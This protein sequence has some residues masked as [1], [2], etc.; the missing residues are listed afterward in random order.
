MTPSLALMTA[1]LLGGTAHATPPPEPRPPVSDETLRDG[2]ETGDEIEARVDGDLNGDGDPDTAYVV[3]S[4]DARTLYVVLSYRTE[5]DFGH[6]PAGSAK[7]AADRLGEHSLKPV[8][9][10][11]AAV[12]VSIV[13]VLLLRYVLDRRPI[14]T[15]KVFGAVAAYM[16]IA[17][18]FACVF[19]L[20]QV[21]QPDAF[22]AAVAHGPDGTLNWSDMM[23]FSFTVL[24]ST[25]FGEITPATHMARALIVLEQVPAVMYVAFL[26]VRLAHMNGMQLRRWHPRPRRALPGFGAAG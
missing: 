10:A 4:P 22:N 25:G 20:L 3:A 8:S 26:V 13:T 11:M 1:L 14:T 9:L 18:S 6:D 24:T 23:Y 17:L 12:F 16:L 19:G 15:D 21:F 5:V 2:L 7:L